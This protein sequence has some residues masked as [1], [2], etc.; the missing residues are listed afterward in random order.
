MKKVLIGILVV[1]AIAVVIS[2]PWLLKSEKSEMQQAQATVLKPVEVTK[3]VRGEIR[4]ELELSGTIQAESQISVF[5]KVA[6]RLVALNVDE[7]DSVKK[8]TSLAVVEHE[9]LEL[10]VQQAEATLKAAET[11]YEQ[12]QQLAEVR[13]NSQIAQAKAQFRAAEIALQQVVDLSEIR[14]ITQIEQAQAVLESLVANLQKIKNGARDEDRRQ[15]EAGVSQA[16]ANLANA[17]SNHERMV[18]LFQNG[19]ISQQSVESAKT[20]LDVAVAQQ[21]IASEQ[22]QLID[23]G[24]RTEDIQ[25]MEA[26]VE[27]AEASLRLAQT[28][29]STKTWEKDIELARS[30]VETARAGLISAEALKAAKS[31]EAEITSAKTARTQAQIALKLAQKRL[32][33]ATIRAPISGIISRR[34][35]DLGGMALPAAPLFEIV[36][37]DTVKA[38]VEVIEVQLSQLAV[39]QQAFIEIDG[40]EGQMS[41]SV[42]FI[43]PTLTPAR[44]TAIVE[45]RIDNPKG[46]LKPG[47]FAEVTIPIEV[48]TDAILISRASLIEDANAKTQN[49]F[50]IEDGVSQR[51]VVEIGL[52]RAGEA[53]VLSGLTEGEATVTAGQHSLKDGESVRVVNP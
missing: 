4:S 26:Q 30:Q 2:L 24:A 22:L 37:I 49:V 35:L 6:G 40:I 27:Q 43:S 34:S 36:N 52:L 38:T 45:V 11:A 16:D 44:R 33:D 23:N 51:R 20:Q 50:V 28:Q 39:N 48:H 13:I 1:S 31:W 8:G 3:A 47:M 46:T 53:E 5:P 18:Q 25:A 7:G 29:A 19:A 32:N 9:E 41:G 12:T 17:R 21:K 42:A 14:T 15:A 10:A